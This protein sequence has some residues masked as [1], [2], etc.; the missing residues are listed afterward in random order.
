MRFAVVCSLLG[1]LIAQVG[2]SRSEPVVKIGF[3]APLTG[4]QAPHGEDMLRAAELA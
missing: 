3:V 2:C 4:D 1:M